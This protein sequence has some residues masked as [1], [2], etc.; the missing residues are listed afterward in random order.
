L[1]EK[2]DRWNIP[3]EKQ[4]EVKQLILSY[5]AIE[6]DVSKNQYQ[7]WRLAIGKSIF[8]LYKTGTLYNNQATSGEV[9]ELREKLSDFSTSNFLDTGKE[10]KI[11]LDETGKGELFGHE[12][13]CG[14]S[15]PK[16]LTKEVKETIG[17][18]DTKSRRTFDYWDKLFS[19][20]DLLQG[21]GLC[22]ITKT[23]PPWHIDLYNTN[24]IMDVVY[25]KI[26][27]DLIRDLPLEQT[28]LVIDNYQLDDNL[29][30]FLQGLEKKGAMVKIEEKA[31]D[32]F[33][34][35]KLAS[36]IAKR[37]REKMMKGINERFKIAGQ[38]PGS[39]NL[40]DPD[41]QKWL[42]LWKESGEEWPWFVK[43]SVSTIWKLDGKIGKVK[44]IDPPIRHEL[45]AKNAKKLFEEGKLSVSSLRVS[46]PHCG[47]ELNAVK[48]TPDTN[49]RLEGRCISCNKVITDLNTTLFYYNGYIVPDSSAILSGTLSKDLQKG[50]FFE[51]FTV[52]LHPRMLEECDNP[53]GKAE[54]GRISDIANTGR[55][56]V[57]TLQDIIDYNTKAD[58]EIVNAA[59]KNNAIIFTKDRGQYA[60]ASGFDLFVLTTS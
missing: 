32:K 37:D 34:E 56:S 7:V 15:F 57:V 49:M 17:L 40:T 21:K 20:F 4:D 54:L 12:F 43:K 60:K 29:R 44:K 30:Y 36:T 55:I 19:G 46:C 28:S 51:N 5:G 25:K 2:H 22:F 45:I 58:D 42:K 1:A 50:K 31:D 23:I 41:T 52:F 38:Q 35:A 48:L 11:G 13:L 24:K 10:I 9:L 33:L 3:S 27:S 14:V 39:G 47:S 6:K 53:G 16:S 59:R 8:D 18:A 26:I